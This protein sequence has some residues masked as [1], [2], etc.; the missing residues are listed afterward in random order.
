MLHNEL[1]LKNLKKL[2]PKRT[3]NVELKNSKIVHLNAIENANDALERGYENIR[4]YKNEVKNVESD[5]KAFSA[6]LE[7]LKGYDFIINAG[8][9]EIGEMYGLSERRMD[10][11]ESGADEL[12]LSVNDISVYKE[13]MTLRNDL[14][15]FSSE[16]ETYY[17]DIQEYL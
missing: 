6:L 8:I 15:E 9:D 16:L 3:S 4:E 13:L 1:Y 11:L 17:E 7:E 14:E 5:I 10:E 2:Y 12:G